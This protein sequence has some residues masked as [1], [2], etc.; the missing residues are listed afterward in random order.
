[1]DSQSNYGEA[2]P[3]YVYITDIA[4][5]VTVDYPSDED[6]IS[7]TIDILWTATD[8]EDAD[9]TLDIKIEYSPDGGS[10][11][12]ILENGID[13]ND[14]IYNN[15]DTGALAD[16][17]NY[18]IRIS[19][20]DSLVQTGIGV[21][22][23]F[24][25]DNIPDDQWFLQIESS[26]PFKDLDMKPVETTPNI[27]ASQGLGTA[28]NVQI[29]T[30]ETTSSYSG[31]INGDWTFN[32]YGFVEYAGTLEAYLYAV[33]RDGTSATLDTTVNDNENI[34]GFATTHLFTWSDSLTG[35]VTGTTTIRVELWI[36]V[37][38]PSG[39]PTS[40]IYRPTDTEFSA[41]FWDVDATPP[42][43]ST[44]NTEYPFTSQNESDASISDD[45][46][47][48]SIDPG[49]FD[50]IFTMC[51]ITTTIDPATITNIDMTFE[52]QGNAATD[53]QIWV[54][55]GDWVQIGAEVT[56]GASTDIT[57][58][59][60]IT[61]DF[62]DYVIGGVF[63][64]GCYQTD[65]SDLVRVDFLETVIDY[66]EPTP[67]FNLEYDY[68][69]T[70]SNV[71]PAFDYVPPQP[72]DIDLSAH[73]AG[74]WA[75]VSF[76]IDISGSP[77]IVLNDSVFGDGETVW[78]VIKYCDAQDLVDPWKTY[79]IGVAT[80]DLFSIDR[81]MGFWIHLTANAGD[82]A[83]TTGLAGT[84]PPAAVTLYSGWNM[85]GFPSLT[86]ADAAASLAGTGAD[87]I[88]VYNGSSPY[89]VEDLLVIPGMHTMA[90]GNGWLVHVPA[91]TVWS[92][93][94]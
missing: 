22:A 91:P 36:S 48:N 46:R 58:T 82:Q 2:Y 59:R 80:N 66:V 40:A 75:F 43:G 30:W 64:W 85:V 5:T 61:S 92:V 26:G 33:V 4:P 45:T 18:L 42:E 51:E 38:T 83:L 78:D 77:E 11:W 44:L 37:V 52:G 54:Y 20:A 74:D 71:V 13:N 50:E 15:W 28:G 31:D 24:S 19:A 49:G 56:A 6:I 1:M 16:G 47:A 68:G 8:F 29:G 63:T 57:I 72:Y 55:N 73:S 62:A 86:P 70:Q 12:I 25:I 53:F 60:S 39:G 90:P 32:I 9:G 27:L 35:T 84:C 79:R 87:F 3:I 17:V 7:G 41:S 81:T 34:G 67:I 21:S 93:Q 65:S 23:P 89:L 76:P 10:S 94:P 69:T 88:T 14:G